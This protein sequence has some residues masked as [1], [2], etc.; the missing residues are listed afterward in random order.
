M[1]DTI[2][3]DARDLAPPDPLMMALDGLEIL[4]KGQR[5]VMTLARE[6][7]TL[8]EKASAMGFGYETE[9]FDDGKV[10]VT[11][12]HQDDCSYETKVE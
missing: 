8:Y 11:L 1:S 7:L 3:L 2:Y 4:S 9:F 6:P 5:L 10:V 12:S